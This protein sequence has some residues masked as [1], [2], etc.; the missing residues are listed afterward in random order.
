M[1]NGAADPARFVPPRAATPATTNPPGRSNLVP[2]THS[3]LNPFF[4]Y[5]ITPSMRPRHGRRRKRDL[6]KTLILLWWM[7]WKRVLIWLAVAGAILWA[8]KRKTSLLA[9][10][11]K[12]GLLVSRRAPRGVGHGPA[13]PIQDWISKF[14][15]IQNTVKIWR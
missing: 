11:S 10:R 15:R 5:P 7:K 12:M 6:L 9:A 2:G 4:G 13:L 8:A 3:S 14:Q 1:Q